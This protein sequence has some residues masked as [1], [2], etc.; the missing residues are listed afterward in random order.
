MAREVII[1]II[2][3]DKELKPTLKTL[4]EIGEVDEKNSKQF[5]E[6]NKK[7]LTAQQKRNKLLKE[8][9]EDLKELKKRRDDAFSVKNIKAFNK[10]IKE[11]EDRIKTLGGQ[12]KKQEGG[13]SK[14][15]KTIKRVGIT[16]IAAFSIQALLRF[17]KEMN[18]LAVQMEADSR[19]AAQ[20][21]GDELAT[22]TA[23]ANE[24]AIALGLTA[25]EYIS[26][27]AATQDMLIPL[28][29]TRQEAARMSTELTDLSG[30]LSIW[31][32]G[33]TSATE[34]STIL[35]KAILGETERLK[36]LGIVI[37]QSSKEFNNRI[38]LQMLTTGVTKEQAKATDILTQIT[39]KS[40]DAQIS[41]ANET[42]TLA[43]EQAIVSAELRT[44]KE[45]FATQ[46]APAINTATK[47]IAGFIEHLTE[48][49]RINGLVG[50]GLINL[51]TGISAAQSGALT[52]TD[53]LDKQIG[54]LL[55]TKLTIDELGIVFDKLVEAQDKID[56][57]LKPITFQAYEKQ[58]IKLQKAM[59]NFIGLQD[60]AG[61]ETEEVIN[62]QIITLERLR[63]ELSLLQDEFSKVEVGTD[64]FRELKIEIEA[65][66]KE[67]KDLTETEAQRAKKSAAAA[68]KIRK[69]KEKETVKAIKLAEEE[70]ERI[71]DIQSQRDEIE[72]AGIENETERR[73]AELVKRF[74]DEITLLNDT[75]EDENALIIEKK[76]LLEEQLT[77]IEAEAEEDRT[78]K[79]KEEAEKRSE[80]QIQRLAAARQIS[81]NILG[82]SQDFTASRIAQIDELV[83]KEKITE[84][85]GQERKK[86]LLKDQAARDKVA[87]IFDITLSIAQAVTK[88]LTAGPLI[89]QILAGVAAA[90]GAAQLA[91]VTSTPLPQFKRGTKGKKGSGM[92][93]VGE[94]GEEIVFLP[95][96]AKVLPNKQTKQNSGIIDAMFDNRLDDYLLKSYIP[97]MLP[98]NSSKKDQDKRFIESLTH[99]L[100]SEGFNEDG[101]IDTLKKLDK[102]DDKRTMMI[103]N[104]IISNSNKRVNLRK[105]MSLRK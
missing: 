105:Q 3:D 25:E 84:E 50:G 64:R 16:L 43:Q 94:E 80:L 93:R 39:E 21:F 42:K 97:K 51:F 85:E 22:V 96:G 67:I 53:T 41:F 14:L 29:F 19:R 4:E 98:K 35:S 46:L 77:E 71:L 57:K 92:S 45:A 83:A 65:A 23:R 90:T 88:A 49:D 7:V 47:A 75:K 104:A 54:A 73:K 37:D 60:D 59:I 28:K 61:K 9:Q 99:N 38:K 55:E 89:G 20:V 79:A 100:G 10:S 17:G 103:A 40:S 102:N 78:E 1:K 18:T 30:V 36:T 34:V 76:E 70:A 69:A 81:D 6:N 5:V 32:G 63:G 24:N 56:K 2:G 11:S 86:Q 8:E 66:A 101:I 27:A 12:V 26:A 58:I 44:A 68:D 87:A 91:I 52:F 15:N 82:V 74:E 95:D 72:I 48:V 62:E 13:M 33:Q 31:T